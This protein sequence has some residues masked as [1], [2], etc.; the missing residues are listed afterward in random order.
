MF[1]FIELQKANGTFTEQVLGKVTSGFTPLR[2]I[3]SLVY[4]KLGV[5]KRREDPS[6][7]IF[8]AAQA[9]QTLLKVDL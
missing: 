8:Y 3:A 4:I 7:S 5:L 9:Y 6:G 2:V 1:F